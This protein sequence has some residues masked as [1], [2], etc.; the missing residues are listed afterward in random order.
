MFFS[1]VSLL[2]VLHSECFPLH[3]LTSFVDIFSSLITSMGSF[4]AAV[5]RPAENSPIH[6][7][8]SSGATC[9]VGLSPATE[10]VSVS[11]GSLI[12]FKLE[13]GKT[14][15]HKGPAAM[16]LGKAPGKAADWDGSGQNWFKVGGI[17][18]LQSPRMLLIRFP[19]CD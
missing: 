4:T 17:Y 16:Y 11:A 8:T 7:I 3:Q 9:N 10:T 6:D 18:S 19:P 12:G 1:R 2:I 5:R 15:Y 14:I 13:P